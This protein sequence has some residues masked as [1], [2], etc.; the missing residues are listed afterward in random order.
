ML[1]R[2]ARD[3]MGSTFEVLIAHEE[4]TYAR[5]AADAAFDELERLER[6]LSRFV[7]SSDVSQINALRARESVRVGIATMECLC[8]AQE[9]NRQTGGAFDVTVGAL[10][11]LWRPAVGA[12]EKGWPSPESLAQARDRTG[13][14]LLVI[15]PLSHTV[16]VNADGV[17][18]DLGAVGKGYA[19]DRMTEVLREWSIDSG[20][21]HGG[22]SSV[23]VF[24]SAPGKEGNGWPMALRD[25]ADQSHAI[26][27]VQL[28]DCS[29]SGSGL[30]LHGR[31]IIDP[32]T[33]EPAAG[34]AATWAIAPTAALSDA[35]S[36]AF[37]LLSR[38]EVEAYCE[39]HPEV[40]AL[41]AWPMEGGRFRLWT[42]GPWRLK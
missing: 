41:L 8:L 11:E 4:A 19:V 26:G 16:G 31:H 20:A 10:V 6:E 17:S 27:S 39:G 35:T 18:V 37:M 23:R 40:G 34:K 38:E 12:G 14:H 2:F 29:L 13:M 32:R 5:Q 33:G 25:P 22:Q 15:D 28:R 42:M 24:G 36:T 3:A 1:H 21:I 30:L 9:M 7:P